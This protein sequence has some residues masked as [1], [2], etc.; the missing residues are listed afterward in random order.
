[1]DFTPRTSY[2]NFGNSQWMNYAVSRTGV[3]MPNC[4][5]YATARISEI[6]GH[7]QSL[8]GNNR[9]VGA[10]DLWE[11]HAPEFS[12]SSNAQVGDLAIYK[13]GYQNF[14]HVAVV[15]VVGVNMA[16]SQSNYGGSLFEFVEVPKTVGSY[17]PGTALRLVGFLRHKELGTTV[18]NSYNEKQLISENGVAILT[19]DVNKRRDTPTGIVVE[20]LKK[21]KKLTYTQKWIGNGHRYISWVEKEPNG[22]QYRYFVAISSSEKQGVDMWATF[23]SQKEPERNPKT[24]KL[25]NEHGWAKYKVDGVKIRLDDPTGKVTGTANTNTLIEYTQKCATDT[26]RYIVYK[27]DGHNY[28]V[29]CSPTKDR[30]N[31]WCDFYSSDPNAVVKEVAKVESNVKHWGVDLSEANKESDVDM[32]KYDFAMIRCNYGE[33]TSDEKYK[34]KKSDYWVSEC[35]KHNKPF[36]LYCYDYAYNADGARLEAE[37]A[38]EL[39]EQYQ[40]TLGIWFDMEDADNWKKRNGLLTS[41]HCTEMCKTFCDVIKSKEWYTGIYSSTWWFDNLL[42]QGLSAFDKWVANWGTNNGTYQSDTSKLGTIHQYTSIDK[43]TGIGLDKNAMYV[44]FEHYKITKDNKPYDSQKEPVEPQKDNKEQSIDDTEK[45][46]T[47]TIID[48]L[49]RILSMLTKKYGD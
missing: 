27:K 18:S 4:F 5:T 8:D 26:H 30:S 42:T 32:S 10:G 25:E 12:Q 22:N 43:E 20:T 15:E 48:L 23:E 49:K 46:S 28:F 39:A 7:N 9:V 34:D 35:K 19:Q 3:A 36:G 41:K 47:N 2:G 38:L 45:T 13:G 33:K 6:V 37:Y 17:Y 24:Y 31:A 1:M 44:D 16:M 21:G 29:A 14:G 40:P 11:T